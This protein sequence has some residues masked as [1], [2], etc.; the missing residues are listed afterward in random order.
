M[1]N[2]FLSSQ[3]ALL[4]YRKDVPEHFRLSVFVPED[5]KPPKEKKCPIDLFF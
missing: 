3:A 4:P 1:K 2:S 5:T